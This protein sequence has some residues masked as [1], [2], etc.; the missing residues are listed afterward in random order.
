MYIYEGKKMEKDD[1]DDDKVTGLTCSQKVVDKLTG[2]IWRTNMW[3]LK[4]LTD[5]WSRC[6]S[7][8]RYLRERDLGSRTMTDTPVTT[9]M[10]GTPCTHVERRGGGDGGMEEGGREGGREGDLTCMLIVTL[11]HAPFHL[12]G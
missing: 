10:M 4:L 9:S 6:F 2:L 12:S 11:T 7:S 8:T 3:S 5:T 1:D